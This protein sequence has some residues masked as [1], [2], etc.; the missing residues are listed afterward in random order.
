MDNQERR[1]QIAVQKYLAGKPLSSAEQA[2]VAYGYTAG[3]CGQ[4]I[5]PSIGHDVSGLGSSEVGKLTKG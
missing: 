2:M 5:S 4:R 1:Y 3:A